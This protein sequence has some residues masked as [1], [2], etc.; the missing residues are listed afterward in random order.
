MKREKK[1][2]AV[3]L[4]FACLAAALPSTAVGPPTCTC[5]NTT[6]T[7]TGTGTAVAAGI[8]S[9]AYLSLTEQGGHL[10]N[11]KT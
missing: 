8:G 11:A 7:W 5:G 1:K 4:S 9:G 3:D 10:H 2:N 6:G